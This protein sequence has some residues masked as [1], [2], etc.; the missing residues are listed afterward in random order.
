[1]LL[2]KE[3]DRTILPLPLKTISLN[4]PV[5]IDK[6]DSMTIYKLFTSIID[7]LASKTNVICFNKLTV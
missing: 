5:L 3:A 1:V 6:V 2:N 4:I 7:K